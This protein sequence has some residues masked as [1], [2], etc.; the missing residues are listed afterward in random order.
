MGWKNIKQHYRIGHIVQV[1]RDGRILIGSGYI[2]DI[3]VI[4]AEGKLIKRDDGRHNDD[5]RRYQREF[6]ADPEKLRL[7]A[8]DADEAPAVSIPV[9]TYEEGEIIEDACEELGWPNVTHTGRLMYENTFSP[10]RM[11]V[12][13]WAKKSA[14]H[15]VEG[16]G[17]MIA[18]SIAAHEERLARL[19]EDLARCER[20]RAKLDAD[21][22]GVV[23]P[24]RET[25]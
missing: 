19:R 21:F 20:S 18:E 23:V 8:I 4:S 9:F 11:K 13:L 6:D 12:V 1:V 17:R 14:A 10:D 2:P 16:Y 15:G 24:P 22:P 5:L 25:P 3:F 7:L